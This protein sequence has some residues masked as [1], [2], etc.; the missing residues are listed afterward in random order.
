MKTQRFKV[1]AIFELNG[2]VELVDKDGKVF[3]AKMPTG[4]KRT[5][6]VGDFIELLTIGGK[7]EKI[8]VNT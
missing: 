4:Q 6:E 7:I 3:Y 2:K 8:E 1:T 5:F